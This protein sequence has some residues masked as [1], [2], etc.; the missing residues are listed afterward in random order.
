MQPLTLHLTNVELG[1][2][3]GWLSRLSQLSIVPSGQA[4][5]VGRLP[6]PT[7]TTLIPIDDAVHAPQHFP[8]PTLGIDGSM[9]FQEAIP[10]ALTTPAERAAELADFLQEMAPK[11]QP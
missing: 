8:G 9:Q 7:T 6:P 10:G 3:L 5:L 11:D 1:T 4:V 2:A